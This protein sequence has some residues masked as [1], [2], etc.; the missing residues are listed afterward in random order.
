MYIQHIYIYQISVSVILYIY[1]YICI[2]YPISWDMYIYIII[3][4]WWLVNPAGKL[5]KNGCFMG[6]NWIYRIY[7]YIYLIGG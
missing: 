4:D 5:I 1:D 3:S 2:L 6:L 7:I